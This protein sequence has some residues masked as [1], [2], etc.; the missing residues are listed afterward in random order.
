MC[1][2]ILINSVESNCHLRY[3]KRLRPHAQSIIFNVFAAIKNCY[4]HG[5]LKVKLIPVCNRRQLK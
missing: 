1:S 3:Q 2:Y 4:P 5:L